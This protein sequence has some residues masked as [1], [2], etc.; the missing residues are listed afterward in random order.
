M[1]ASALKS[2]GSA[3]TDLVVGGRR[4]TLLPGTDGDGDVHVERHAGE[5]GEDDLLRRL[6]QASAQRALVDHLPI[7]PRRGH[8]TRG[9]NRRGD[10]DLADAQ[11]GVAAERAVD[12]LLQRRLA[13]VELAALLVGGQAGRG[14]RRGCALPR[15][16]SAQGAAE[17]SRAWAARPQQT[18][19]RTGQASAP[20]VPA[21]AETSPSARAPPG[22]AASSPSPHTR[23]KS[24]A[25]P[26]PRSRASPTRRA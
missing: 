14:R 7:D 2:A 13:L 20:V 25:P 3:T 6:L 24:G 5:L 12:A 11:V 15:T 1:S 23:C 22:R 8:L 21:A 26:R 4:A 17:G 16:S 18:T 19:W 10:V 9:R